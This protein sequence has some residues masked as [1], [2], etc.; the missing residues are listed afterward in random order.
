MNHLRL[1]LLV[2]L[3]MSFFLAQGQLPLLQFS[4][5]QYEGAFI[6]PAD[7]FGESSSNYAAGIFTLSADK[8]GFFLAGHNV[9]GAIAEFEM[10]DLINS[11]SLQDLQYATIRQDF[12]S[13]MYLTPDGNP[14]GID[15]IAGMKVVGN[16]LFVNAIEYY[17]APADNTHTTFVVE[18]ADSLATSQLT[19]YYHVTGQAHAGGWISEVPNEWSSAFGG[20]YIM[21]N[22]SKYAINSRSTMGVSAFVFDPADLIN[23]ITTPIPSTTLLDYDLADPLYADYSAYANDLYNLVEVNGSTPPG[24]TFA[25]ADAIVGTNALWT[26]DSQASFGFIIPGTRTYMSIGSSGGHNS[27]IGYKPTQNNGNLCGGPCPYDADDVYNY[28]WLWDLDDLVDVKNGVINQYD[29]RPYDYGVFE[30]PFQY[31]D[32]Y[33]APEFHGIVGGD[34]DSEKGILYLTIFDGGAT[35]SPYAKNPVIAAYSI[36][37]S[38]VAVNPTLG[39]EQLHTGFTQ[40]TKITHAGDGSNRLFVAEKTGKIK[41]IDST[42]VILTTP[43]LDISGLLSTSGERGLLGLA[44]H[45]DY[46]TNGYF[47]VNYSNTSGNTEIARYQVSAANADVADITTGQILLGYNQPYSNHNGGDINFGP[48]DGFLYIASGDGGSSNDP[49][50]E[51]QDTTSALGKLL[52]IDVDVPSGNPANYLIPIDNPFAGDAGSDETI[53]AYGL[54]NPWRFS[55][56]RDSGD[57]WIADVGQGLIEEVD[58][59]PSPLTGGINYGWKFMEGS[60]CITGNTN[61]PDCSANT[62]PCDSPLYQNPLF[63][64]THDANTGGSSIT[65]GHVY[66]GCKYTALQ[67]LY[68]CA[69][70]TS[71]NFWTVDT[72]GSNQIHSIGQTG[73]STFGEDE[74]GELYCASLSGN[75]YKVKDTTIPEILTLTAAD[76]PLQGSYRAYEKI[77]VNGVLDITN[78]KVVTFI[79]PEVMLDDQITVQSTEQLIIK[80]GGCN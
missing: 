46:T 10:P 49:G 6:V 79:T 73:I 62:P 4:D 35:G 78:G 47:Y 70:Y 27:G 44:F 12:K 54:R 3:F 37:S 25:D 69:D 28:Y 8:E 31:D 19:G 80:N 32:Y 11:D 67:G 68:I 63:E 40:P 18:V 50:C 17:D 51:A 2:A 64:Y 29:V 53:W 26:A 75:I 23:N 58:Y 65:G 1:S 15:R 72:T 71:G 34:F 43:F 22:S 21:G 77:I 20:D 56:D 59:D 7:V 76:S 55:F 41:I 42:G 38:G 16:K 61:D 57:L 5:L 48:Q 60:E 74:Q 9:E 45:P 24:H 36:S 52:R 66:R 39:L 30:V 33:S 14:Q 13:L